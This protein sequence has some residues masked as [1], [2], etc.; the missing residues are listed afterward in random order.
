MEYL[1]LFWLDATASEP[2]V[3]LY[4]V[5]AANERLAA[6]SIDIFADR[7]RRN[8]PDLYADAIEIVPIPTAEEL[9]AA[10]W[11]EGF[12]ACPISK[13]EFEAAWADRFYQGELK[14]N[15]WV[16]IALSD[17]EAHMCDEAV[18]Q[19]Q[20]LE[21]M[22]ERQLAFGAETVMIFGIAGGNGLRHADPKRIKR[23]YGVD[24]NAS[25]LAAC[26]QRYP[27]LSGTLC[28]ICA[29]L[30]GEVSLPH[31]ELLIANLLVEYIGCGRFTELVKQVAPKYVSCGIQLDAVGEGE[32]GFVSA[33]PY[34]HIFDGL[35]VVHQ[36]IPPAALTKALAEAGYRLINEQAELLPG[37][38]RLLQL[39]FAL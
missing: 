3:I 31:A 39:D 36:A 38:K 1:K 26:R 25:Y 35:D 22:A 15:P 8:I 33:S 27:A 5:D 14:P 11:G 16:G 24:V 7:H 32:K 13:A 23:L 10:V 19:Q 9:N 2:A 18:R 21:R 29:D 28:C 17:Y 30:R 34:L 37:E 12:Y 4:E 20:A 6:R